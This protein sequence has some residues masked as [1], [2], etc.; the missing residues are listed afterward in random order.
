[1]KTQDPTKPFLTPDEKVANF[2]R[3][4]DAIVAASAAAKA[5]AESED[6]LSLDLWPDPVRSFPNVVFR[7]ALFGI[8][9]IRDV[10][11]KR[12]LIAAV[13]GIEIRFKGERFNQTDLDV[14][15]QLLHMA[16]EHPLGSK[17]EFSAHSLLRALGR[18]VARR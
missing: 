10:S 14:C 11:K 12:T 2:K 9:K 17:I 4:T 16:R 3:K 5:K 1:M 18:D 6:Q 7:S 13:E 15:E 8:S